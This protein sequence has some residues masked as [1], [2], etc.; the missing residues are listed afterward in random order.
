MK[1]SV[2]EHNARRI[3][4][5]LIFLG[6]VVLFWCLPFDI[7]GD[8]YIRFRALR[9]LLTA[10]RIVS[11][12]YSMVGP[13][14]ALP[15]WLLGKLYQS[16]EWWVARF[17]FFVFAAGLFIF[18]RLLRNR[19]DA[20]TARRFLLI[21][22]FGSM[23][24][25][26]LKDFYGEVFTA[27]FVG[28]GVLA[29]QVGHPRWGWSGVVVGA[30]N[31]PA[32]MIGLGAMGLSETVSTRRF[33]FLLVPIVGALVCL[34]ESWIRRGSP[35]ISGYEGNAGAE[36]ILTYSGEPGFSYPLVFGL[37][38]LLF[39]FGKGLVFFAPGLL[40]FFMGTMSSLA[41]PLGRTYR[42]WL[43][44]LA[45]L[46]VVYAP[47]W[48][49]YGGWTWGPR[50]LFFASIPAAFALAVS[51]EGARSF[52]RNL[53]I[54][55][56]LAGSFWVGM[57]GAVFGLGGLEDCRAADYEFL[58]WY[59]PEFSPL[60]RP[61]VVDLPLGGK[62]V[63]LLSYGIVVFAYLAAPVVGKLR[64]AASEGLGKAGV[65]LRSGRWGF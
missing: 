65:Y 41:K 10:E 62:E 45:G 11:M 56:I 7:T 61:F 35:W 64:E 16:A 33:R 27:V 32:S 22:M 30:A 50:Y 51:L 5:A 28:V 20:R 38:S 42:L 44:F 53:L 54:L 43:W 36:T 63:L 13:L 48:A 31:T 26:H 40:L 34:M 12:S 60:W 6:L 23:F 52:G 24:P 57:S 18:Y 1:A 14:F 17:N 9:Y 19:V 58:C 59:V 15:L 25:N 3:E 29:A 8:G 55:G 46:V 4:L 47:W 39:S 37:L 2:I 49:W 21:L